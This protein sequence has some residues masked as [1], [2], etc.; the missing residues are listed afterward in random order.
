MEPRN[1]ESKKVAEPAKEARK[2]PFQIIKLEE[3]IAPCGIHYRGHSYGYPGPCNC[4]NNGR[5][6]C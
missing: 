2:R 1:E 5:W 4:N 6:A 3:R